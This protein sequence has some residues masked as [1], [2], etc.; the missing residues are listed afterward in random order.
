[1]CVE[2]SKG[3]GEGRQETTEVE[4]MDP[5]P[6]LGS[7]LSQNW[8]DGSESEIASAIEASLVIAMD[9]SLRCRGP[10]GQVNLSSE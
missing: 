6:D 3:R 5:I 10:S 2:T 1:M 8:D 4:T 9:V 7:S